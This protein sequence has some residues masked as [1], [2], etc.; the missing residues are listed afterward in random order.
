MWEEARQ[1]GQQSRPYQCPPVSQA[2][3]KNRS[4]CS[5][6]AR[7]PMPVLS[8]NKARS[9]VAAYR[10]SLASLAHQAHRCRCKLERA[11]PPL[12]SLPPPSAFSHALTLP[13]R[14]RARTAA[15]AALRA[16]SSSQSSLRHVRSRGG[17]PARARAAFG[18]WASLPPSRP[19]PLP[20]E[21]AA[22]ATAR[23][24]QRAVSTLRLAT[25]T[26]PRFDRK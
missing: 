15:A 2:V 19:L 22:R 23:H 17:K 12:P 26:L 5:H 24:A 21:A 1:H 13:P 10:R 6:A 11:L 3:Q 8:R 18:P 4:V 25:H 9:P 14:P 16:P 7:G 20:I